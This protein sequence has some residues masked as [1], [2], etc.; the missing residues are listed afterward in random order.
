MAVVVVERFSVFVVTFGKRSSSL[1]NVGLV[2]VRAGKSVDPEEENLSRGGVFSLSRLS[3]VLLVW[4]AIF[5]YVCLNALVMYSVSLPVYV[6]VA[7]LRLVCVSCSCV[8][9]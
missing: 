5:R 4:K 8:V 2:A 1:S 6:K 7:H 3:K 9:L